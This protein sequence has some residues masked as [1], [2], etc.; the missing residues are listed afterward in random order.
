M[1]GLRTIWKAR[2]IISNL[3]TD[4]CVCSALIYEAVRAMQGD[5]EN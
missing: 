1:M 2:A 4:I 3:K 5:A